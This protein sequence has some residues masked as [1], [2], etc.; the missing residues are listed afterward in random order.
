MI[1]QLFEFIGNHM[2]LVGVFIVLVVAFLI[3]EGKRGGKSVSTTELVNLVNKESAIILDIRDKKD[4]GSGHIVDAI[5]I[6]YASIDQ[7]SAEINAYK[8][9][10]VIVVCKMG[11]TSTA[12]GKKL[13][14]QG[15]EDVRRL[16][17]GM[18]EWSGANLPLIKT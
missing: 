4:F 16:S 11:Q 10:P 6:P 5:N 15:F 2:V 12:I 13:K 8:Q 9:K 7:R 18:A 14:E 1:E 3:N 17:G